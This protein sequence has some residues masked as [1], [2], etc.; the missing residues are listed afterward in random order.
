MI[1]YS[2]HTNIDPKQEVHSV[3]FSPDGQFLAAGV[4]DG[5]RIYHLSSCRL[6]LRIYTL[7][8]VLCLHWDVRGDLF[9]GCQSGYLALISI[10][11]LL[12]VRWFIRI[13]QILLDCLSDCRSGLFASISVTCEVYRRPPSGDLHG[14][15]RE[16]VDFNLEAPPKTSNQHSEYVSSLELPNE[17]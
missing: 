12:Q 2:L 10:D 8:T 9:G 13:L 4:D 1:E 14:H 16:A 6:F 5:V 15:G 3:A 17:H 11:L 7:S